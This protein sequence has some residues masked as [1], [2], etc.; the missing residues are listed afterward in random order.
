MFLHAEYCGK[1][2]KLTGT[3]NCVIIKQGDGGRNAYNYGEEGK[4]ILDP[5]AGVRNIG[6]AVHE[7][8]GLDQRR[9]IASLPLRWTM[10]G[11]ENRTEGVAAK[12][13]EYVSR[14]VTHTAKNGNGLPSAFLLSTDDRP[15]RPPGNVEALSGDCTPETRHFQL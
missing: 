14:A 10:E 1:H 8:A 13:E 11:Q 9:N 6:S 4:R 15:E 7:R 12:T 3:R 5:Q 2:G